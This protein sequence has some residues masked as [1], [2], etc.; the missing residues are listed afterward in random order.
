MPFVFSLWVFT[1]DLVMPAIVNTAV[2]VF[3]PVHTSQN[4][5]PPVYSPFHYSSSS[6]CIH[7]K[8]HLPNSSSLERIKPLVVALPYSWL[9]VAKCKAVQFVGVNIPLRHWV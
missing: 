8:A 5:L 9:S 6:I 2:F 1:C 4:Q 7:K 3:C